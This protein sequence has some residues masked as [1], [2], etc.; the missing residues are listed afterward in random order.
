[1][2]ISPP[3]LTT[4]SGA[5]RIPALAAA[6]RRGRRQA[7][8]WPRRRSRGSAAAE[9][10][11]S[12]KKPPRAHGTS[13]STS[14][15]APRPGVTH[16][17]PRCCASARLRA[18]RSATIK[19]APAAGAAL[20]DPRADVAKADH[21]DRAV[22]QRALPNARSQDA[23]IAASTPS[24]VNGLGSPEPPRLRARPGR[25]ASCAERSRSCHGSK[26]QRPRR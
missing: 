13:T 21:A 9:R 20:G 22:A 14:Q 10:V 5:H 16:R 7:G 24:A 1:M 2:L 8:C 17:A 18:S 15:A 23:S 4:K 19:R 26:C 12:S 11:S 6:R 3:A 25:R